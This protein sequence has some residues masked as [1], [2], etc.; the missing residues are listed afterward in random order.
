MTHP[1]YPASDTPRHPELAGTQ[2]VSAFEQLH[3][4]LYET[5]N[6]LR[7][8]NITPNISTEEFQRIPFG[9]YGEG[10]LTTSFTNDEGYCSGLVSFMAGAGDRASFIAKKNI[11]DTNWHVSNRQL[12]DLQLATRLHVNWP[13]AP[14]DNWPITQLVDSDTVP[15]TADIAELANHILGPHA[16]YHAREE[17]YIHR[18]LEVSKKYHEPVDYTLKLVAY[19]DGDFEKIEVSLTQPSHV[20]DSIVVPITYHIAFDE[21][22]DV[23]SATT[24]Y[25]DIDGP[26]DPSTYSYTKRIRGTIDNP[27][28]LME[29]I[30]DHL[31]AMV[32]ERLGPIG[33]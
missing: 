3:L 26:F 5:L 13:Q 11:G 2:E 29:T 16:L 30:E 6:S 21:L 24:E 12:T 22:G 9:R 4:L 23:S 25:P 33:N 32:N 15:R 28:I 20:D 8:H 7:Q 14:I 27:A 18:N 31:A 1:E 17:T 10:R 19:F